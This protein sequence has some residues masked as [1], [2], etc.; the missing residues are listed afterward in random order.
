ML[1]L[2]TCVRHFV[3]LDF[4]GVAEALDAKVALVLQVAGVPLLVYAQ[5]GLRTVRLLTVAAREF[6]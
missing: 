6:G 4:A 1:F 2:P 3:A 5:R